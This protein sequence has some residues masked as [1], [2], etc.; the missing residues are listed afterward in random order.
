MSVS[1]PTEISP[2]L[3]FDPSVLSFLGAPP[4][5]K[6]PIPRYWWWIIIGALVLIVIT[7]GLIALYFL[8]WKKEPVK[9]IPPTLYSLDAPELIPSTSLFTNTLYRIKAPSTNTYI[10]Q[11][12]CLTN[13]D[14]GIGCKSSFPCRDTTTTNMNNFYLSLAEDGSGRVNIRHAITGV[15]IAYCSSCYKSAGQT[16]V[17][18]G[19]CG[20]ADP[21]ALSFMEIKM[22]TGSTGKYYTFKYPNRPQYLSFLDGYAYSGSNIY[23]WLSSHETDP[24]LNSTHWLLEK[25]E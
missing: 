25:A 20:I 10:S 6:K 17:P 3:G 15:Y 7:G 11:C 9:S 18:S 21:D 19:V 14:R 23:R 2:Q 5:P 8:V 12:V 4:T 24:T 13:L 16:D 22:H 1:N